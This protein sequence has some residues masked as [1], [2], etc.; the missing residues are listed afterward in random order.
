MNQTSLHAFHLEH[1]G[2]M[3]DFAGW[4]MPVQYRSILDEHRLVRESFGWFDVSHMG[5]FECRGPE[6][7]DCLDYAFT[8]KILKTPIGKGVYS[9]L[10][11]HDG[12]VLDDCILYRIDDETFTVVV[13]ASNR[14]S[15]FEWLTSLATEFQAEIADHTDSSALI[16]VQGPQAVSTLTA[17]ANNPDLGTT[18]RFGWRVIQFPTIAEPVTA[19]R[20]GYTGEDGFELLLPAPAAPRL[21]ALL[22]DNGILPCGLGARD[23]L[24]LE[25]GYPLYGHEFDRQRCPDEGGVSWAVKLDKDGFVG[26]DSL[27][28]IRAAAERPVLRHFI[29][30]DKRQIREGT[31]VFLN[32]TPVGTVASAAVSPILDRAIGSAH[33][34]PA[35]ATEKTFTAEVRSKR[36]VLEVAAPPL[37]RQAS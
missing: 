28:A 12:G 37:H 3:V 21:A 34:D 22:T 30:P 5:I 19:F 33:I 36:L 31:P 8:N 6:A 17:L 20:T 35:F 2:R 18:P 27:A 24:R 14:R 26:Q 9:P 10:C 1:G 32:D 16:A 11:H 13:N 15:D 7:A 29:G 4:E 23:S 25:A